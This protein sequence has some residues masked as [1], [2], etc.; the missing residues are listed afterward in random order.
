MPDTEAIF[1]G[2]L[3]IMT[4]MGRQTILGEYGTQCMLYTVYA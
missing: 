2:H 1:R 4:M 3:V